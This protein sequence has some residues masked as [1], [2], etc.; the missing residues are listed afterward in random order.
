ML[1]TGLTVVLTRWLWNYETNAIWT[2]RFGAKTTILWAKQCNGISINTE[3]V[4]W[5]KTIYFT[6]S[7]GES[8]LRKCALDCGLGLR[9]AQ[10]LLSKTATRKGIGLWW[11]LI[12]QRAARIR[13]GERGREGGARTVHPRWHS[14]CRR[15]G[16]HRRDRYGPYGPR[17]DEPRAPEKRGGES[18]LA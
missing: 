4:F 16:G 8:V 7:K 18:D 1:Q 11:P 17:F 12:K 9:K 6:F 5:T 3:N 10:G 13:S 14:H 2:G 15:R